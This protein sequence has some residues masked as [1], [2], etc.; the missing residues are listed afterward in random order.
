MLGAGSPQGVERL[1][2]PVRPFAAGGFDAVEVELARR[3]DY[4]LAEQC[5]EV[6][7]GT[8]RVLLVGAQHEQ[9]PRAVPRERR[10]E[11]HLVHRVQPARRDGAVAPLERTEQ[12]AVLLQF[13]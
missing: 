8:L 13:L 10:R 1:D 11:L 2:A 7:G 12:L 6:G 4:R 3:Q 9:R 5:G